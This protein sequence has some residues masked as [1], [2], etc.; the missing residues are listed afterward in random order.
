VTTPT[1]SPDRQVLIEPQLLLAHG[2]AQAALDTVRGKSVVAARA[3]LRFGPG[4]TCERLARV[5]DN[6][7]MQGKAAGV[8]LESW[9][10][11]EGT[12]EALADIVR[13][14]RLGFGPADWISIPACRVRI[15]V[16]ASATASEPEE[17][18]G[19]Q[20]GSPDAAATPSAPPTAHEQ[21][22][23]IREVL[24]EVIDPDLGVNV[25]DLGF[26]RSI[27]IE[28]RTAVVT[29][30]LTSAACP[31]T[32]VIESQMRDRLADSPS[33][34]GVRVEWQWLPAWK[35]ADISPSGR[36]QL[37]AIGFTI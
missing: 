16:G 33:L 8:P 22:A 11:A 31:L 37:R 6:A 28:H 7:V 23:D 4:R 26:V 25:V 2:E 21:V 5:L 18:A 32:G 14:R 20:D 30:T 13:V 17:A 34:D 15:V 10:V 36:E 9:V 1:S 24:C 19:W 12:A 27:H 29:M 3:R 35:P